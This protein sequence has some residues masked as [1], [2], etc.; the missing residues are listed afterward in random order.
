[1]KFLIILR[2]YS[3]FTIAEGLLFDGREEEFYL[4]VSHELSIIWNVDAIWCDYKNSIYSYVLS[5]SPI[6]RLI[7]G[8]GKINHRVTNARWVMGPIFCSK[9]D[10]VM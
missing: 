2:K 7:H 10:I 5:G 3:S 9:P 1:M 4:Y 8:N 6:K